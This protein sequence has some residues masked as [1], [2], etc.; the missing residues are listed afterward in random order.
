MLTVQTGGI[1]LQDHLNRN[2]KSCLIT[3]H[4][5]TFFRKVTNFVV[6]YAIHNIGITTV[7]MPVHVSLLDVA[8]N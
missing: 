1:V 5:Q 8:Q 4:A 7:I 3:S 2:P 6:E